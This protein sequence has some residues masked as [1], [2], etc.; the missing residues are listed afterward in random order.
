MTMTDLDEEQVS[1][2]PRWTALRTLLGRE[3]K[4]H[5][6]MRWVGS[7]WREFSHI[8]GCENS[9]EV[10]RKLGAEETDEAFD[11]WLQARLEDGS[12]VETVDSFGD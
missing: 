2:N 5:E 1:E 4:T 3:P 8:H 9:H 11:H 6:Y 12:L 10:R 7:L